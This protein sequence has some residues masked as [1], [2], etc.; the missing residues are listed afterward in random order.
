VALVRLL[1]GL[2]DEVAIDHRLFLLE[3]VNTFGWKNWQADPSTWP[4][5]TAPANE[6]VHAA[7]RQSARAAE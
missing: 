7:K 1:L 3:D 4:V 6:A 2:D 5:T